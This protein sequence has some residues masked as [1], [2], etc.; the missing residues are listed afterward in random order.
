MSIIFMVIAIGNM[1]GMYDKPLQIVSDRESKGLTFSHS[2]N[3]DVVD[4]YGTSRHIAKYAFPLGSTFTLSVRFDL[5]GMSSSDKR[6]RLFQSSDSATSES[7]SKR[8]RVPWWQNEVI[9]QIY[10]RSFKDS[11]G[12]GSGDLKG[13]I[14][15]LDYLKELGIGAIWLSPIYTSPMAD[16]GY[17]ISNFMD[18]D[19]VFGNMTD[20]EELL[21][22]C[23]EKGLKVIMDFVPNH[24][25]NEHEWFMKSVQMEDPYTDYYIWSDPLGF[26]EKGD[27]IPPNNW[28]SVFRGSAWTWVEER[29][30]FYFHQFLAKQPD[31]NFRN[32]HVREEMKNILKFW[33]DKGVDGFRID[34]LKHLF[35]VE[36][37][38]QDEPI[39]SDSNLNY[40]FDYGSLCHT[41]TV[42]QP[43]T[44]DVLKEWR[45]L[46]SQYTDK[47]LMVEI[48]DGEIEQVM[49]Y[50][51]NERN[52]LADFP[53]NFLMIDK[54]KNRTELT[55]KSLKST[56]DIWMDNMPEGKWPNWVLGNHDSGRMG[57]RF[58]EDLIDALNMLCLLLPG[59]PITYYGEEIGMINTWISWKDTQDP[60]GC[61]YGPKLYEKYSRDPA[62]T[63]MQWDSTSCAGFTT[64]TETWLPINENYKTLNV[65]A[66]IE[67]ASSH[68][69]I[70]RSLTLLRKEEAFRSGKLSYPVITNDVFSFARS[71]NDCEMYLVVINTSEN[72]IMVNMHKNANFRLPDTGVVILRSITDSSENT[73][74][75]SE[76][77]LSNL[78]M[79][80]GEGLVLSLD[81]QS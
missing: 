53:F 1:C 54:L 7:V 49:N 73:V 65:K 47:L 61:R 41:L 26:T 12:L 64:H 13:I 48:Y 15:K 77:S 33:L 62:R 69:K 30:Q 66:Q 29:Q 80:G 3:L 68:L 42:N 21:G 34:A 27:P 24:S 81:I 78:E 20:F 57:S 35:E 9:Y 37:I 25:S 52:P 67:A 59:T 76:V 22:S 19:P 40:P 75:H 60:Q 14:S 50:Y 70:Y 11:K 18:I 10:P 38:Y 31:L 23:H 55:G 56:V 5:L 32:S 8:K 45:E 6:P 17:D 58:G 44:F 4:S 63:P 72:N 51:G 71:V 74:P 79:V 28:V 46:A 2:K 16:F 39:A 43:E 36:D